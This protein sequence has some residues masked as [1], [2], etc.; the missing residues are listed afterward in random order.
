MQHMTKRLLGLLGAIC[1]AYGQTGAVS[2]PSAGYVFDPS[3][4]GLRQI[5]GIPG[6]A[7]LG[8]P[9]EVGITLA[10]AEIAPRGD[11]AIATASDGSVHL[12]RLQNGVATEIA[13]KDLLQSPSR[14][15]YSP[16]GSSAAILGAGSVQILKGLPGMPDVGHSLTVPSAPD[17]AAQA[18]ASATRRVN[19]PSAAVSDDGSCVLIVRDKSV[20]LLTNPGGIRVLTDAHGAAAV[21]FAPGGRDA[22]VVTGGT[23]SLFQD[24]AGASTRQDFPN[25]GAAAALAF[26]ADGG[27]VLIAGPRAVEVLDRATGARASA[28]CDCRLEGLSPMGNFFRLN[29]AGAGPLWLLDT[30]SEPK[31]FFVPAKPG[32]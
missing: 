15:V 14:V 21:A 9:L 25:A 30:T 17:A 23:L 28:E 32:A 11:S 19:R 1:L 22:A 20:V 31:L 24:V 18:A 2:G 12:L 10:A 13:A 8:D 4:K 5:R 26:S 29:E 7:L 3:I 6:A 16:S 27:K